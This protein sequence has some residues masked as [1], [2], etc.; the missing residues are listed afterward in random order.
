MNFLND[1]MILTQAFP[2]KMDVLDELS[3]INAVEQ[4]VAMAEK[5]GAKQTYLTHCSCDLDYESTNSELPP[6][7]QL[8]HDGQ[9][10]PLT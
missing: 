3:V 1:P 2:V 7:I 4:A 8:A 10:I 5:L 6:H 9:R